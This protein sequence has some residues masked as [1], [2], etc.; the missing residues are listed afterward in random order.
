VWF[1]RFSPDGFKLATGS[2]D[3]TVVIWDVDPVSIIWSFL[4][5]VLIEVWFIL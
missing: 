4:D 1:C 2:K 3:T 5:A